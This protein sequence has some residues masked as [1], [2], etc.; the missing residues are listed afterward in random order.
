MKNILVATDFSPEAHHAFEVAV[1][2]AQLTG[3]QLTLLHVLEDADEPGGAFSTVG[4]PV[5]GHSIDQIFT[6]KL[7]EATKRRMHAL[8]A[9]AAE[10][11]PGVPVQDVVEVARVGEGILTAIERYGAD[12]VV[13]GARGHGAMEHFFVSST[14]E[15]LIRLA[16]CPVLTV[17]HPQPAFKVQNIVFPSDFSAE[18]AGALDGLRQVLAAFPDATLHLL[19]VAAGAG[20]HV[21]QQ[22]MQDFAQQ[23]QLA[24]CLTAEIDANRT[25]VGIEEYARRVAADVVVIPTHVRSG[26]SHFLGTSIAETVATHAFPPVLTYHLA[27]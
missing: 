23:H 10:W 3:G 22:Q 9:E 16:P 15:R 6:I 14:T 18:A 19:H 11:A 12:L 27:G 7:M 4:G 17:K 1:Q 24:H 21:A 25:S 20:G 8:E 13:V 5:S 26:L 2:L